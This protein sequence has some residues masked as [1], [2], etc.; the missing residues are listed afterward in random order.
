MKLHGIQKM[1]L[2]DFPGVVS[3]TIFLGGCDFRCPFC[4]NFE[5]ID[6]TAQPIMDDSELIEFL[7]GRKALIDGVAITGGEPCLH[8]DLPEL[9][10]KI[11]A[12]GYKVKLDTNG[13]HPEMLKAI[14]DEGLVEYVAM[15]IKN[16]EEKYAL[17]C[18]LD[19]INMDTIKESISILMNGDTDYEFRTTVV[20]ELH[21][22][23]D[24]EKIG[25]MI[26]GAKH[27]FLQ[28]FTD[29]DSVPYGNLSAPSFDKMH[30]Y[31]DIAR[32]FVT[33]TELRGVE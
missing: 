13:Y 15:D 3:C 2:L 31:C 20:D 7:R 21:D 27:Y 29:R 17:T 25:E 16:S 11:R 4:H 19:E 8:K 12:E 18:G 1:T 9:I 24:F 28:R 30:K 22:E 32:N 10:R 23:S 5:L 26:K 6:G 14:L 33:N